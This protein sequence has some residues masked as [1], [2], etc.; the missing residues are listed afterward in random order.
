[1]IT[2]SWRGC[3]FEPYLAQC[4][5][6]QSRAEAVPLR[7]HTKNKRNL[8][9]KFTN[10]N[11]EQNEVSTTLNGSVLC[12]FLPWGCAL[13]QSASILL[14]DKHFEKQFL[15]L[16]EDDLV[17]LIA[18]SCFCFLAEIYVSKHFLL[19]P[20]LYRRLVTFWLRCLPS[21]ILQLL[22]FGVS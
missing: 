14:Q 4:H 12:I 20:L 18:R 17:S 2:E 22:R 19:W 10:Q 7:C 16:G 6:R 5:S 8:E 15:F 13:L 3:L 21:R 11:F 1:M 9:V